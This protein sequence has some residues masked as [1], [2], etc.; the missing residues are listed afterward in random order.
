MTTP[1]SFDG[2]ALANRVPLLGQFRDDLHDTIVPLSEIAACRW[3]DGVPGDDDQS[4]QARANI[5]QM[6]EKYIMPAYQEL[7][8]AMGFQG[9]KLGLVRQIGENTENSNGEVAGGWGGG[10]KA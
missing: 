5:K 9:E 1:L 10:H 6:F 7:G 8:D 4:L 3:A 2:D